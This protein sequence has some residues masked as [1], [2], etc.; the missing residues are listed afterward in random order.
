MA[1]RSY[2]TRHWETQDTGGRSLLLYN[3]TDCGPEHRRSTERV[4]L[5]SVCPLNLSLHN[6]QEVSRD[7][8]TRPRQRIVNDCD[9][10]VKKS[11]VKE[12]YPLSM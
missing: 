10:G 6:T 9:Y 5:Q 8:I 11:L 3:G 2:F 12:K 4:R 7:P 1:G